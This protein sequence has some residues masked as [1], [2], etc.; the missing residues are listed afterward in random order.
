MTA[1]KKIYHFFLAWIGAVRYGFPSR[2][3]FVIGVTGT[4]G[5]STTVELV[6]HI[7]RASGRKTALFSTARYS[8][9]GKSHRNRM[10][11]SMPGRFFLQRF[12]REA[13]R[14]GCTHVVLEVS[15]QGVEQFRHRFIDFDAVAWTNL[16][17][18]HIESHGSFAAYR[19]AK[20]R[21]FEDVANRSNK[22]EKYFFVNERDESR[23]YFLSAVEGK[24]KV[25]LVS[26]ESFLAQELGGKREQISEWLSS[27]F[28]MENAA[29]ATAICLTLGIPRQTVLEALSRFEGIPGRM[30]YVQR[31]PFFVV[32]D[33]AHTPE[34]L[35]AFYT[36]IRAEMRS[37]HTGGRLI[38]VLGAAGGGRDRWKRPVL[39][40]IA[41]EMVDILYLTS[42]DPY[43]DDPA[44]IVRE[45]EVGVRE[46]KRKNP[47]LRMKTIIDRREAIF[48]A[49]GEARAGDAVVMTGMG[50]EVTMS[51][52]GGKKIPWDERRVAEEA[53]KAR[54][55]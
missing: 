39:G 22:S 6:A 44:E 26:R 52:V 35:R 29:F 28:N 31:E 34:S 37:R 14:A 9:G 41:G 55:G 47:E 46:G 18:E 53:I 36:A 20:V 16:H 38:A 25:T 50:S 24:G 7:L 54:L 32:V 48:A 42:E 4:K 17:P 40:R 19:G 21:F 49:V 2:D 27:D 1:F 30:E 45:I 33:Y 51:L 11:M 43:D 10:G 13:E 12:L 15:S 8:I 23:S 5:K 3:L